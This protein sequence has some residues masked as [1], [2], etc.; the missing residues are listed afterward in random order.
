MSGWFFS[1]GSEVEPEWWKYTLQAE[2]HGE[3]GNSFCFCHSRSQRLHHCLRCPAAQHKGLT[4]FLM[5]PDDQLSQ[6]TDYLPTW[7]EF[8]QY[9]SNVLKRP[10]RC[11][12]VVIWPARLEERKRTWTIRWHGL[13]FKKWT[14]EP[15]LHCRSHA[16]MCGWWVLFFATDWP[17]TTFMISFYIMWQLTCVLPLTMLRILMQRHDCLYL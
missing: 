12:S 10:C 4:S 14:D 17:W 9:N 2:H 1:F 13:L 16:L 11:I 6:D 8:I 3:F 5:M 7:T 15:N